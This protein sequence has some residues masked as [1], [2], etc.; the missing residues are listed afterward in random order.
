MQCV[1]ESSGT[2]KLQLITHT[3]RVKELTSMLAHI[4]HKAD[5]FLPSD[6]F[7]PE[8]VSSEDP[9]R[10]AHEI[11]SWMGIKHRSLIFHMDPD[12]DQLVQ[13]SYVKHKSQVSFNMQA[14][15]NP[16]VCGAAVAHAITHHLIIARAKVQLNATQ[17]DEAFADLATVYAGLGILILNSFSTKTPA[18]GGM[19]QAN[20]ASEFLDYC[21]GQRIVSSI[22]M[23]HI[24]PN[25]TETHLGAHDKSK[26]LVP[27]LSAYTKHVASHRRGI[28]LVTSATGL[29]LIAILSLFLSQ[30][31]ALSADMLEKRDGI[32]VLKAQIAH[33]EAT[34]KRKLA[35][36]DQSDIFI[37][38]QIQADNTRCNSLKS[39]YNYEVGEYTTQLKNY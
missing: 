15:Q 39:R 29:L 4:R 30:P 12:Q 19:A 8:Q 26:R 34:V 32:S 21:S 16:F 36:W 10:M 14:M 22:W 35:T 27:F 17:E 38:R 37:E 9:E 28:A 13:Y 33:C 1:I 18:L 25:I 7:Y 5:L 24:L 3:D 2:K 11:F 23:P 6:T 31:K 20:Y